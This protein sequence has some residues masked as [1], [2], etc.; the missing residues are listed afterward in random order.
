MLGKVP[1][2]HFFFVNGIFRLDKADLALST[3]WEES[4][5]GSMLQSSLNVFNRQKYFIKKLKCYIY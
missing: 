5:M 1:K 4:K 3:K 2:K